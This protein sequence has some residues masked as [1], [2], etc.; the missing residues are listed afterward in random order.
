MADGGTSRIVSPYGDDDDED[1]VKL[2]AKALTSITRR[3]VKLEQ[4]QKALDAN[5]TAV[6]GALEAIIETATLRGEDATL[7]QVP[8]GSLRPKE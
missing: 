7:E 4:E 1:P 3:L 2:L 5:M 6:A 8:V